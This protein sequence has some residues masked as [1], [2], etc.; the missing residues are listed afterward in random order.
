MAREEREMREEQAR[1]RPRKRRRRRRIN[2]QA[3]P[4]LIALALIVLV[5]G[6][7]TGRFLYNK[8][9]FRLRLQKY[10]QLLLN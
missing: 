10:R 5:G 4:V 3:L 6:F 7:M 9:S 8:Y 2:P 1:R